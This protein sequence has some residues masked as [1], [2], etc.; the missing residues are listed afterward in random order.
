MY[1]HTCIHIFS[2]TVCYIKSCAITP[3]SIHSRSSSIRF[4]LFPKPKI[5]A[6]S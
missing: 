5:E 1:I 4:F 2:L 3:S 6:K